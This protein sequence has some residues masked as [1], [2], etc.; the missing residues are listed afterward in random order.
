MT[1]Y[2]ELVTQIRDYTETDNQVLTDAII[3]DFIEHAEHRIFRDIELNSDNV[4][5]N[6]N[7][8][9]NNRF[10]RLPGFSATDPSKPSIDEIATIRYVTLYTD[11][12][13]RTRFDLVR[14][15]QDFLAEYYDTPEVGS[16]AKPRY[17]AN[18]DM[19]TIVVAPTPN[20]VYK[21]EIGI[22]KKPTG[23][24][25]SNTK[26]WVSVNAPNVI[27]YAC[28][29]EAFKFL[30]APQDQQ[31]YEASYQEAIQ[32]LAQEQLGKKR[33]DEFRDGSLRVPI[34]SANP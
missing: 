22:T 10:V 14:V 33:R 17:F 6:G 32:A 15:D 34:P 13:P 11:T 8:A 19:G 25:S 23:L 2:A 28:L 1:T 27:L 20:A 31:V 12:A 16:S 18:W 3:N 30:K 24:S 7:T 29:C 4:Y 21:F 26:T 9:A 5:V